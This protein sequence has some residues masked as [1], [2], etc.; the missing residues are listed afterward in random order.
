MGYKM[1]ARQYEPDLSANLIPGISAAGI[2]LGQSISEVESIICSFKSWSPLCDEQLS[3]V[4]NRNTGWLKYEF[5]VTRLN[6]SD[7]FYVNFYYNDGVIELTVKNGILDRILVGAGYIGS[8]FNI[9]KVGSHVDDL[10][11]QAA[12]KYDLLE[13]V[14]FFADKLY[15]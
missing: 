13:E 11:I 3:Q 12:I 9:L 10:A 5:V 2:S 8:A 15:K 1:I 4:I 7:I 6:A 14:Y